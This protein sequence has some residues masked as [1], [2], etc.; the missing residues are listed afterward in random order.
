MHCSENINLKINNAM[1]PKKNKKADL[2]WKKPLFFQ[3][4]LF[5][6]LLFVFLA[7]EYI[8]TREKSSNDLV[9]STISDAVEIDIIPTIPRNMPLP[10]PMP[11]TVSDEIGVEDIPFI[12]VY[13]E[14]EEEVS[15]GPFLRPV[16][17]TKS[18]IITDLFE[19]HPEFPGGE[20]ACMKFLLENVKYPRYARKHK[21]EGKVVLRFIIEKD[22][23]ISNVEILRSVASC[24]DKEAMRVVRLMPKWRPGIQ[25]GIIVRAKCN[26]P[27]AFVL[28]K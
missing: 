27:I 2:E 28:N 20:I 3:V 12:D 7:F 13:D 8:G 23:S 24:L 14:P 17:D 21:I 18:D 10:A 25:N 4:G 26:M 1:E 9:F 15:D 19:L 5:V 11:I 16:D 6:S 22:G